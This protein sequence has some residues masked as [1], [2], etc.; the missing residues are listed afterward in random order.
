MDV[1]ATTETTEEHTYV[2]EGRSEVSSAMTEPS[3]LDWIGF[4]KRRRERGTPY[5]Y[6]ALFDVHRPRPDYW[7]QSVRGLTFL[8][9]LQGTWNEQTA[10]TIGP[11]HGPEWHMEHDPLAQLDEYFLLRRMEILRDKGAA[12][13]LFDLHEAQERGD[14]LEYEEIDVTPAGRSLAKLSAAGLCELGEKSVKITAIG[15]GFVRGALG[16]ALL[17]DREVRPS[18]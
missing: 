1:V 12:A 15:E 13:L 2:G 9:A 8:T 6:L 11:G 3:M 5:S 16:G 17:S 7:R 14:A 4:R 10:A 18:I